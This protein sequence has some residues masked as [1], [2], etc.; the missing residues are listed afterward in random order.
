MSHFTSTRRLSTLLAALLFAGAAS[1]QTASTGATTGA[2]TGTTASARA[3]GASAAMGNASQLKRADSAFLKNAAEAGHTEIEGSKLALSKSTNEKVKTFAQQMVGDH[4]KT[5][6][7]LG[8]LAASKGVE[9]PTG[10][11]LAQKARLK[12]LSARDGAGFDKHYADFVGVDAHKDTIKL[13][14]KAAQ[15]AT[16]PEVKAFATKTLPALEHHLKMA[17][18][19]KAVTDQE[20]KSK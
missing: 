8:V 16:D 20:K 6:D 5:A 3:S 14:Q 11:S 7:E 9:L 12:L 4:T 2:T 10:P 13:F 19:L 1:A 18:D 17:Q 15:E